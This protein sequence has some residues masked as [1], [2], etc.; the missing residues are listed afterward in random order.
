MEQT[1]NLHTPGALDDADLQATGEDKEALMQHDGIQLDELNLHRDSAEASL[2]Q[3]QCDELPAKDGTQHSHLEEDMQNA[4]IHAPSTAHTHSAHQET[5]VATDMGAS[6][7]ISQGQVDKGNLQ[8]IL[9]DTEERA[10]MTRDVDQDGCKD[11]TPGKLPLL[12]KETR[13]NA[14]PELRRVSLMED[15]R[16]G[17][18]SLAE[19]TAADCMKAPA[20]SGQ[21]EADQLA[22]KTHEQPS[23]ARTAS[24]SQN[25]PLRPDP[26]SDVGS[27]QQAPRADPDPEP[28]LIASTETLQQPSQQTTIRHSGMESQLQRA[29]SLMSSLAERNPTP[30]GLSKQ[31]ATHQPSAPSAAMEADSLARCDAPGRQEKANRAETI[32]TPPND[33]FLKGLFKSDD[34]PR[35]ANGTQDF[36]IQTIQ[37]QRVQLKPTSAAKTSIAVRPKENSPQQEC[38]LKTKHAEIKI[39]M[40][41]SQ[42]SSDK[43]G[44]KQQRML[45][46]SPAEAVT[47]KLRGAGLE[48]TAKNNVIRRTVYTLPPREKPPLKTS[49]APGFAIFK[50][51]LRRQSKAIQG[52]AWLPDGMALPKKRAAIWPADQTASSRGIFA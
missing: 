31:E 40:A 38:A 7:Q 13:E 15:W 19:P 23:E 52:S 41:T 34:L 35:L 49:E 39:Q 9:S 24:A 21:G 29:P 44:A 51:G 6:C 22:G 47:Q 17:T 5:G 25:E 26:G 45:G 4:D 20:V 43:F 32:D 3:P 48:D 33:R 50:P 16:S 42:L 1:T 46:N 36:V 10:V 18:S 28:A 11:P 14:V 30:V 8:E 27:L 12:A 2:M 37:D